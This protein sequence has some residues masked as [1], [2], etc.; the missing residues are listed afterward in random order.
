MEKVSED[1]FDVYSD[2]S[3]TA[4]LKIEKAI[5]K[6]ALLTRRE[7]IDFM[8]KTCITGKKNKLKL[9][10]SVNKFDKT[11]VKFMAYYFIKTTEWGDTGYSFAEVKKFVNGMLFRAWYEGI[12]VGKL[13]AS[14]SDRD[15]VLSV[16]VHKSGETLAIYHIDSCD[17][18]LEMSISLASYIASDQESEDRP[19]LEDYLYLEIGRYLLRKPAKVYIDKRKHSLSDMSKRNYERL[20]SLENEKVIQVKFG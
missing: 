10:T 9:L 19:F 17:A 13:K 16:E 8:F 7:Q 3:Y 6:G 18:L 5:K 20:D 2:T 15:G 1:L 4:L 12:S 11:L 14:Y